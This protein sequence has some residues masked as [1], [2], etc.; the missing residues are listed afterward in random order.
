VL[1]GGD[2]EMDVVEDV[3]VAA[4]YVDVLEREEG[5]HLG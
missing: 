3:V 5:W 1:A 2:G 4:G